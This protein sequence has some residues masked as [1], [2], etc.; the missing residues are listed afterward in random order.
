MYQ[1]KVNPSI[2]DL[3]LQSSQTHLHNFYK[4]SQIN[5]NN[6]LTN[7][8][9]IEHNKENVSFQL[10]TPPLSTTPSFT[11]FSQFNYPLTPPLSSTPSPDFLSY[12]PISQPNSS[13][14]SII[15]SLIPSINYKIFTLCLLW[16]ICSIVSSN[17]TK[18]IL[19]NFNYP[20]TLT[21]FQFLLNIILSILFLSII[22]KN[23]NLIQSLPIGFIPNHISISNFIVPTKHIISTTLSMGCFQFIGHLTSHNATSRIPV[24]LVHTIKSL[25]PLLTV[26][27]YRCL[28]KKTYKLRTYITLIPLVFGIMLTC[29]KP[30]NTI[31]SNEYLSGLFFAFISM[32]IFVSQNIFAKNRLTIDKSELLPTMKKH[33]KTLD[34]LTILFYCSI[35]G[36]VLTFPIYFVSECYE[37]S[38]LKL[39]N[40]VL[41]LICL[42]GISHFLQ[43]L[44]AFQILG[45][46]N[47]INYSIAN[48]LKRIFIILISFIY[49]SKNF[50]NLQTMGLA[51]TL[52]GLYC[53]DKFG[54]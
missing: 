5:P 39:N 34:K 50:S 9:K 48:I 54:Q 31:N 29:Y 37:F 19:N 12:K 46:I 49:E 21:Q 45:M 18:L 35:I 14:F 43:S 3:K 20:I 15:K 42:N 40:K 51:I 8:S 17:S 53:Y 10:P 4:S 23:Q 41:A 38:L 22:N 1:K 25:S 11:N 13:Y 28:F 33:C 52:F 2:E 36:F 44:L 24:S 16:Y 6:S 47:P 32:V 7:L 30:N 26:I 27:V